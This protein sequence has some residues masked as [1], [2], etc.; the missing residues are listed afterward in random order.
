[1]Q[2]AMP[3]GNAHCKVLISYGLGSRISPCTHAGDTEVHVAHRQSAMPRSVYR[4]INGVQ[5]GIA[6]ES[7][8]VAG[9]KSL[10]LPARP[11]PRQH[12][13]HGGYACQQ[14]APLRVRRKA[15][16]RL[17][18]RAV[19]RQAAVVRQHCGQ[20]PH[21]QAPFDAQRSVT[22]VQGLLGAGGEGNRLQY[23]GMPSARLCASQLSAQQGQTRDLIQGPP[24]AAEARLRNEGTGCN[25]ND[26]GQACFPRYRSN[27]GMP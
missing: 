18:G 25:Y 23:C 21:V 10:P 19:V 22:L 16:R 5:V 12:G 3:A 13:P 6:C 11:H 1:M 2:A 17:G 24:G 8:L 27:A 15:R 14:L 9:P 20:G 26:T 4:S 7:R